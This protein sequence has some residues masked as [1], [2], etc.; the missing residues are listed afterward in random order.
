MILKSSLKSVT[1]VFHIHFYSEIK[2]IQYLVLLALFL[3]ITSY[4]TEQLIHLRISNISSSK[5]LPIEKLRYYFPPSMKSI[6]TSLCSDS[7]LRYMLQYTGYII[8][9]YLIIK[10][11]LSV[12]LIITPPLKRILQQYPTLLNS[13][14]NNTVICN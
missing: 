8:T 13:A 12:L 3:Q 7:S 1:C 9:V 2:A 11:C 5:G 4:P 6:R 10:T 14:C